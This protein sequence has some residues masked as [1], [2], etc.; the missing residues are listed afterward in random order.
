ML[1][2]NAMVIEAVPARWRAFV[3][4]GRNGLLSIVALVATLISGQILNNTPFPTGYQIVFAIGFFG[5]A[6]SSFHLFF[7]R[8]L[9]P[10]R[11]ET[12]SPQAATPGLQWLQSARQNPMLRKYLRIL[13]LL[14]CF[15]ISQWLVIPV[16]PLFSVNYL[17]LNDFQIGL[18]GGMFNLIVFVSSFYLSAVTGRI[19]NHR[20]T[21]FSVMG[22][23]LYPLVLAV[24]REFPLYIVAHLLG[25]V[26]YGILAGA[27]F[28]Y[29]AEN[30]P[31]ESRAASVSWYILASNGSIL[32]GSLLGPQIAGWIGFPL[33]MGLFGVL[34][35]LSGMAILRWG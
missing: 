29:L 30:I 31:E 21:A 34:R 1:A 28:N 8:K 26:S 11:T 33:A 13:V 3:V 12:S 25:G 15:H 14:F 17:G 10:V 5:A 2:F 19:G 6:M 23:G 7:L 18:A 16:V 9:A 32:V 22:L 4:G 35:V 27:L 20:S 24:S